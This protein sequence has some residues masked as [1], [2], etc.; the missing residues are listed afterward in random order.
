[1]VV[2]SQIEILRSIC[3]NVN[4]S[5]LIN[6]VQPIVTKLKKPNDESFDIDYLRNLMQ[7]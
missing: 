2:R 7:R 5:E 3:R 1:M 4:L 6:V